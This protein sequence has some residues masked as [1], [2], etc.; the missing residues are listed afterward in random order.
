[1]VDAVVDVARTD[2]ADA[3]H[4]GFGFLA[5]NADFAAAVEA[6]GM[7]WVGPPPSAIRAMGDKGAA[8]RLAVE[9]G[10]PVIPGYDGEDQSDASLRRAAK[11]IG[12]PLLVKPAAGGGGKGMRVVRD[13]ARLVDALASARRE[14]GAAFADERLILERFVEGPRHV[15]VQVL[16]DGSGTGIH[17]GERDCSTQRRHQKVLEET[18]SPAV[19]PPIRRRLTE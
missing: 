16:F 11:R 1:D 12:Y 17:L 14:A 18:P 5:E 10:V 9:L 4:P 2:G 6:A 7:L 13:P 15:E 8:R 3:V 19:T